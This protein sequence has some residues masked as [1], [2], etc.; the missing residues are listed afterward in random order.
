MKTF[1]MLS[2]LNGNVRKTTKSII[3]SWIVVVVV[4][5]LHFFVE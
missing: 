4:I 1:R 3:V 5:I 2:Q